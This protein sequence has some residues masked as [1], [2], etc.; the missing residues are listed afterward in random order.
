MTRQDPKLK[1]ALKSLE[2]CLRRQGYQQSERSAVLDGASERIEIFIDSNPEATHDDLLAILDEFGDPQIAPDKDASETEVQAA[3]L[4]LIA[5][6][7]TLVGIVIISPVIGSMGGDGGAI[8]SLFALFGVP[9]AGLM[10]YFAR[11]TRKGRLAASLTLL[12]A[13]VLIL[14]LAIAQL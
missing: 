8:L 5:A 1:A 11:G 3:N 14:I 12:V 4:S 13:L 7:V 10:A 2:Q 6:C 9:V